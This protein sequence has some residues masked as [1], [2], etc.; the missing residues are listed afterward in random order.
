[1]SEASDRDFLELMKAKLKDSK[2][3]ARQMHAICSDAMESPV[4]ELAKHLHEKNPR[5][6]LTIFKHNIIVV[7]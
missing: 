5:M 3:V 6:G 4:P 1:M 7:L 2:W